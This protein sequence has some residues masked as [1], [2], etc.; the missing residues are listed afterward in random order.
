M[1][2]GNGGNDKLRGKGGKDRICG[3]DGKDKLFG[4]G[5]PDRL[6]GEAG[7]DALV[8]GAGKDRAAGRRGQ[9]QR[10]AVGPRRAGAS[11]AGPS[12]AELEDALD[13]LGEADPGRLRGHR[14]EAG[15]G[16]P[17]IAF[18]SSTWG[19]SAP[20]IRS[21]RANPPQPSVS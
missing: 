9:G 10:E 14:E 6:F 13:E 5:G 19:P 12:R 1:I 21:T 20:S 18:T 17:G 15:V 7:R 16:Q 11:V 4:G 8:G 3:D 2:V